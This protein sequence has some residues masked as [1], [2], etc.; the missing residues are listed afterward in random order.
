LNRGAGFGVDHARYIEERNKVVGL[1]SEGN[2][3]DMTTRES[4]PPFMVF[5][6]GTLVDVTEDGES[7]FRRATSQFSRFEVWELPHTGK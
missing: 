5:D 2:T 4:S 7:D 3:V 1:I 6:R